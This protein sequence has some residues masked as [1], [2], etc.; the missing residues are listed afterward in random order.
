METKVSVRE[1]LIFASIFAFPILAWDLTGFAIAIT[2][3]ALSRFFSRDG[4]FWNTALFFTILIVSIISVVAVHSL[5]FTYFA[6]TT[7]MSWF[8]AVLYFLI[9]VVGLWP[10]KEELE[11]EN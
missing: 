5:I 2:A 6:A 7:F 9:L 10:T 1:T 4:N 8:I 11:T 3:F